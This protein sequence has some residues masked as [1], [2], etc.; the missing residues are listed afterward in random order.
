LNVVFSLSC[1][2]GLNGL[3]TEVILYYYIW[4]KQKTIPYK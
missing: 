3:I 1:E 2:T 4:R